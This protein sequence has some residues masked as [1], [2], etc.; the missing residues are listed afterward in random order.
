MKARK[1]VEYRCCSPM[2][3]FR[4]LAARRPFLLNRVPQYHLASYIGVTPETLSRMLSR[5]EKGTPVS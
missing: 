5:D 2:E 4:L 3:R 1:E